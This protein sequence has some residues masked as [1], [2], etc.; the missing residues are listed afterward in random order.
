MTEWQG[1]GERGGPSS[2][3]PEGSDEAGGA[4]SP[5][6]PGTGPPPAGAASGTP[7]PSGGPGQGYPP[8]GHAQGYGQPIAGQHG[9]GQP[10]YGQPPYGQQQYGQAPYGG[11]QQYGQQAAY[12]QPYGYPYG[13]LPQARGTNTMAIL[14]LVLAFV[15]A[16]L[17]LIL[18]VIARR[19]IKQT[20]EDG[21]GLA[22]AGLIIG[23]VFT[24]IYVAGIVF[25]V[26]ALVA[27]G[28]A[29]EVG[30]NIS[31]YLPTPTPMPS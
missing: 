23:G 2:G 11:Q 22:L 29:S 10:P 1:Y 28:T 6:A 26:I 4:T 20:G 18:G 27:F 25:F 8:P 31:S 7:S 24:A 16:P 12:G 30:S 3:R 9:P 19:Q 14:A 13:A 5:A 21:D 17:G 15:F